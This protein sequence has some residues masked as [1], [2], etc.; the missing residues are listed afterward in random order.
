MADRLLSLSEVCLF[1][2]LIPS[3][4]MF[5]FVNLSTLFS[6]MRAAFTF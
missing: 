3:S 6:Y 1:L 5:A 2:V 4:S